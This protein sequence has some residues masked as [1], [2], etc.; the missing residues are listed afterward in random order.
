MRDLG[1]RRGYSVSVNSFNLVLKIG[2]FILVVGFIGI[3]VNSKLMIGSG[4]SS[5]VVLQEAPRGLVPVEVKFEG[6]AKRG[7]NLTTQSAVLRDVKYGGEAKAK[8]TRSSGGGVY[9]L[10]VEATLPDP[11]NTNYQV[12]L[13]SADEILPIDY[14][15]GSGTSWSLSLRDSDKYSSYDGIWI[16]LERT[17]DDLPEEHVMEGTF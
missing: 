4:S 15:R 10:S 1:Q 2:L 17:K 14:M 12:W 11:V 3:L 6:L 5:S 16:T 7:V 9:V 13:V 8:A